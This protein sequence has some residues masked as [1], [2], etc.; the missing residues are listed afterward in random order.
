MRD[1]LV[2]F[3]TMFITGLLFKGGLVLVF[4]FLR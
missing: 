1:E 3:G 2:L 4:Q